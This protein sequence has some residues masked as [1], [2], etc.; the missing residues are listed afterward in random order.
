[1]IC[2]GITRFIGPQ[3][4]GLPT[5]ST[6]YIHQVNLGTNGYFA[7]SYAFSMVALADSKTKQ[8]YLR[9]QNDRLF[10]FSNTEKV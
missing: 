3:P 7:N 5:P 2:N 8:R 1:M 9:S 4:L 10:D 6:T